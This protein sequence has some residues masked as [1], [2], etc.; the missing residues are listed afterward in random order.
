MA[1]IAIQNALF[2]GRKRTSA[3]V[4]PRATFT[5]P[6]IAHVGITAAEAVACG[7][8][9]V[10]LHLPLGDVDRAVLDGEADGFARAHV[11]R[12]ARPRRDDRRPRAGD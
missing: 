11:E 3:L 8:R 4:I 2:F 6:E 1:R 5:A 7:D 9:V 12:A 10:T